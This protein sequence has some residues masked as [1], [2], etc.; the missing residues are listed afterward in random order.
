V[1]GLVPI[2]ST[3]SSTW[4]TR[5]TTRPPGG[6]SAGRLRTARVACPAC[7]SPSRSSASRP[8]ES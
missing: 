5:A 4:M 3:S 7:W 2:R 6:A 8:I 1:I